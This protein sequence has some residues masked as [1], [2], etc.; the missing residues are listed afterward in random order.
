VLQLKNWRE[1]K[2]ERPVLN[3]QI[4]IPKEVQKPDAEII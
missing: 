1:G 2:Q 3:R 4:A